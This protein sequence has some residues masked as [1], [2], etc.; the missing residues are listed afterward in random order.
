[1]E[2][3]TYAKDNE[4]LKLLQE[5][6]NIFANGEKFHNKASL[7]TH[8]WGL[9]GFKRWH[10]EQSKE[11]RCNYIELQHYIIDM[12]SEVLEPTGSYGEISALDFKEHLS[13]YLDWEIYVYTELSRIAIELAN[14]GYTYE[15]DMIAKHT[16]DVR[17]EIE[18]VR[19][20]LHDF[21]KAEFDWKYIRIIDM[22][23]HDKMKEIE[24]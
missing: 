18:K 19:R 1:M 9:Q 8:K 24:G 16:K 14:L 2:I 15:M 7:N 10:K 23:L 21:D 17:K 20:W 22:K 4:G 6:I 12:F 11:D 13:N 5:A 3:K